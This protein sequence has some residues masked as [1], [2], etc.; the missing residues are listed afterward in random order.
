MNTYKV[1]FK[2]INQLF[3]ELIS[4]ELKFNPKIPGSLHTLYI[5]IMQDMT[6]NSSDRTIEFPFDLKNMDK[7]TKATE[8]QN[9]LK[10]RSNVYARIKDKQSFAFF[11]YWYKQT[12][13]SSTDI[14]DAARTLGNALPKMYKTTQFYEILKFS[15]LLYNFIAIRCY[16][17]LLDNKKIDFYEDYCYYAQTVAALGVEVTYNFKPRPFYGSQ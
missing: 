2:K 9:Y 16:L 3:E 5:L 8:I 6:I 15:I 17:D 4:C 11:Y 12:N 13:I 7:A 14:L 1:N 10:D